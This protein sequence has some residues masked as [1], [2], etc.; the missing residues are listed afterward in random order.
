M[1]EE[2]EREQWLL[3]D[4]SMAC[5]L[6]A[7]AASD[8]LCDTVD[9]AALAGAIRAALRGARCRM[10]ERAAE[11]VA[12]VCLAEPRVREVRVRVEKRETVPGLRAAAAV[13][14][15]SKA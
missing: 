10:I 6:A 2:R 8:A 7:A 11:C 15:R 4:V 3:V 5:D 13:V 9:Y 12:S 1:P 14:V